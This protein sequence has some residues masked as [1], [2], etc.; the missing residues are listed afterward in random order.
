MGSAANTKTI[1]R[2]LLVTASIGAGHNAA[3]HAIAARLRQVAPHIEVDSIDVMRHAPRLFRAYYAGGFAMA[4]SRFPSFYGWGYQ[5]TNGPNTARRG[6]LEHV[7]LAVERMAMRRLAGALLDK[8]PDVIVH[9]HFLAPLIAGRLVAKGLLPAKQM[10]VVTD[11]EVHRRWYCEDVARWFVPND[12]TAAALRRWGISDETITVSGVPIYDRWTEPV[13]RD[14]VMADWRLPA[15]RPI[16]LL[17]GGTDFTCGPVVNLARRLAAEC[18]DAYIVVLAGR[19]KKLLARLASLN[20]SPRRL[21]GV[22][23]T[24]RLH[25]LAGV[26]SLIVTKAGGI[27]TAECLAKALPMVFLRPVPGH[28]AGNARYLADQ[29]AAVIARGIADCARTV[30]ALLDDRS[31]LHALGDNAGRLYRPAAQTIAEAVRDAVAAMA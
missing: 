9:T 15:N 11:I 18:P 30:S 2:A 8:H 20:E 23:F 5:L 13:D 25:E 1:R 7:R 31:A 28:E 24:D 12:Y 6:P 3:G 16:V 17:S 27:M 14:K 4:M 26:A 22:G 10:V 29:G 21:V 19:N